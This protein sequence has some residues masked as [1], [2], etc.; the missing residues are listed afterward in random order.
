MYSSVA[1]THRTAMCARHTAKHRHRG[2]GTF[3]DARVLVEV[4]AKGTLALETAKSVDAV[5]TL[6]ETRQ[7]LA[8]VDI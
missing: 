5:A 7:L 3:T 8:L 1:P 4:V 6:A 2:A